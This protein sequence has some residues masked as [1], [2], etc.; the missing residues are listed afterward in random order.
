MTDRTPIID[1]A[2]DDVLETLQ[3]GE[4]WAQGAWQDADGKPC[5]H[6]AIRQCQPQKGDAFLIERVANRQGWGTA[7][8][9]MSTTSFD[10]VKQV[11]VQHREVTDRDL[12]DTFGPQWLAVVHLVRRA[13]VLTEDE[14]EQLDDTWG[15]ASVA[16]W[17]AAWDATRAATSDA[18]SDAASAAT[19][20]A[21]WDAT[22]DAA[23]DA[24][25]AAVRVA[26]RAAAS[27]A[28]RALAVRDLIGQ[29]GFTQTH[30]DVLTKPW[31]DVIGAI[32]PADE[33]VTYESREAPDGS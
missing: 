16:A 21:A 20:D 6:Q 29:H 22:R 12:E 17:D 23:S 28:A 31:R 2:V 32:H 27:N 18:A 1:V 4:N 9:D 5:L 8:N 30:Y 26:A 3:H 15:A 7:W 19:S 10:D 33:P 25:R 14:M 13:A 11:L 24:T